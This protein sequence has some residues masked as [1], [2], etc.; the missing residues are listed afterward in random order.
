MHC[1]TNRLTEDEVVLIQLG[2]TDFLVHGC[3]GVKVMLTQEAGLTHLLRN[4]KMFQRTTRLVE[5]PP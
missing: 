1:A 4:L 2:A 3:A 5:Q